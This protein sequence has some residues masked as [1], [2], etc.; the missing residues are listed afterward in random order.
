[1]TNLGSRCANITSP[2][3]PMDHDFL[4]NKQNFTEN[5]ETK[6]LET[7]S[8]P[9]LTAKIK[10]GTGLQDGSNNGWIT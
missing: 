9:L 10:V 4:K 8:P 5:K 7:P 3:Y 2:D 6:Q 1:M